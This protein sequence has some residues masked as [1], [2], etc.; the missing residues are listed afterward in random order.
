MKRF[1]G[2]SQ[3]LLIEQSHSIGLGL[4][5]VIPA[6]VQATYVLRSGCVGEIPDARRKRFPRLES[7]LE[8][9]KQKKRLNVLL[10]REPLRPSLQL[11]QRLE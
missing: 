6:E 11:K 10:F 8:L 4:P 2:V 7:L 9:L 5:V 1:A 3:A